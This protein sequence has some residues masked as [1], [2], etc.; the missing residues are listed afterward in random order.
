MRIDH[1]AGRDAFTGQL[2]RL[3]DVAEHLDD[4]DLL[5]ASRCRGWTVADVLT[6]VHLGLQ[7]MLLGIVSPSTESPTVDAVTYW[8]GAPPTNDDR[9]SLNGDTAS[10][11]DHVRYVRLLTS[12]YRRP[13][14][15]IRHLAATGMVVSRAAARLPAANLD[16][17]GHVIATGDFLATWAV[18]L[19]VH[20]L[21]LGLELTVGPPTEAALG[22][23]RRTVAEL[24]G[25]D[26]PGRLGDA[27]AVLVGTGRLPVPPGLGRTGLRLPVLG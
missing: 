16:F 6:H 4:H 8:A 1:A 19:A 18:E 27:E 25:S 11:T 14:G 9:P 7:E 5:A 10:D 2:D 13:S 17:Q 26:L 15:G 24:A 22:L 12:A 23:A 3:L 20:H 21:D